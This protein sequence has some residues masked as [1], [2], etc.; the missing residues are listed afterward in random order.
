LGLIQ[1]FQGA[2]VSVS[3]RWKGSSAADPQSKRGRESCPSGPTGLARSSSIPT[4]AVAKPA[5]DQAEN[6][7]QHHGA[8]ERIQDRRD[9]SHAKMNAETRQQPIADKCADKAYQQISD[10]SEPSAFHNAAGEP[11][12]N[13]SDEKNNQQALIGQ[14]HDAFLG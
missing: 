8:N 13:N 7:Q 5:I 4:P 11:P 10:Q 12:R 2:P 6:Q 14:M 9:H 3:L 1:N